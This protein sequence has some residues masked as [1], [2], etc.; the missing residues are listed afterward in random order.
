MAEGFQ[1]TARKWR[2]MRFDDVVGQDHVTKT[3]KNAIKE[4]RLA[5]AYLFTG[6][7]GCGKTTVARILAKAINCPNAPENGFEPCNTCDVC[8]GI[9]EGRSMDVAEIDG[10]SNNGVDDVRSLRDNV[11]YPPL[12]GAYKV[13]IIDEVHML[14]TSAFNALLKTLEEPPKHL[15]F[16]FATTEVQKVLPT[17]LSRTQRYDFR[18]LQL[19]EITTRL[20]LIA[21]TDGISIDEDAL[22]IIA[23]K[24]DGSMR[25]AQSIFDQVIAFC[26]TE[27]ETAKV[28]SALN[29]IDTDFYFEVSDAIAEQQPAKAFELGYHVVSRGYDIEEFFGGLLEHFRNLLTARVMQSSKFIEVSKMHQERYLNASQSF[30]EGD[31]LRLVRLGT[32]AL[33][34]LKTSLQPRIV[35]EMTLT[36][37]MLMERAIELKTLLD[38][39]RGS[40]TQTPSSGSTSGASTSAA[41]TTPTN[42]ASNI[43]NELR[44]KKSSDTVEAPATKNVETPAPESARSEAQSITPSRAQQE[45]PPYDIPLDEM[46]PEMSAPDDLYDAPPP[47]S[48]RMVQPNAPQ[49]TVQRKPMLQPPLKSRVASSP[50]SV[51][52][53][54][55][56]QSRD[57]DAIDTSILSRSWPQFVEAVSTKSRALFMVMEDVTFC[58][59]R[60]NVVYLGITDQHTSDVLNRFRE[61]MQQQL[62]D[63]CDEQA[64][65]FECGTHEEMRRRSGAPVVTNPEVVT[66]VMAAVTPSEEAGERVAPSRNATMAQATVSQV[67][68]E[69]VLTKRGSQRTPLEE[70]L[71][72]EFSAVEI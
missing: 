69:G 7:R 66:K 50:T 20:A 47:Q 71:I 52:S 45:P 1:V 48:S 37:M 12:Q 22:L 55:V 2:P 58:G 15:V 8:I 35:L 6:Q 59:S 53:Q 9:T 19:E 40:A 49:P 25:D 62:R 31:L 38:E 11:K 60:R 16:V 67:P 29:L 41:S 61:I 70:A 14:S 33:E 68:S 34:R 32:S 43:L 51:V 39:L 26:G 4:K 28:R 42:G 72:R 64:L 57:F 13:I 5:H 63:F 17:I 27:V 56:V 21:K 10:A 24:A 65:V 3:L 54:P 30:S 44:Q 46:V 18:R 36:E 23:K